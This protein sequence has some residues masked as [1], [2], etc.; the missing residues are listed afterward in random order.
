VKGTLKYERMMWE[1]GAQF[2][3]VLFSCSRI[4]NF[5]DPTTLEPGT[6]YEKVRMLRL[7]IKVFFFFL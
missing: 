5:A 2:P 7:Q 1:R 6:G 3:P 4:L